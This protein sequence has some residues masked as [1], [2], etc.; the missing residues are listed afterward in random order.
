MPGT[1]IEFPMP[2]T[3]EWARSLGV[4]DEAVD[5]YRHSEVIDLHVDTFIWWRIFRYDLHRRHGLG[6]LGG[7]FFSQ[8]DLPRALEGGLKGATWII[9]TNP[10]RPASL[11]RSAL[12]RNLRN[13]TRLLRQ[14]PRVEIVRTAAEYRAARARGQ[15]GAFLGIQGGN[16]LPSVDDFDLIADGQVLRITLVHLTSS[17]LG[18]TSAP[19]I[20]PLGPAGLTDPGRDHIRRMNELRIFVDL[21]HIGRR[22]FFEALEVHDRSQ[23]LLVTHTGVDAV[24]PHWRN[25]TD[26]QLRAIADSGGTVGVMFQASFLGKGRVTA[27]TVVDHIAHIVDTV[28]ED[29]ASVGSDYDGAIIPPADLRTPHAMPR[30]VQAMLN[31]GFS[32][33]RVQKILGGNFLRVVEALRG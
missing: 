8:V 11:R 14:D 16:A 1:P 24:R 25:V 17:H 33:T 2:P 27:E 28:G 13:L 10:F 6:P 18:R 22:A 29:H 19:S 7:R 31:R 20:L 9:T 5:L 12:Q 3:H 23:P 4:S 26:E 21:A 30:L 32:P 15:H